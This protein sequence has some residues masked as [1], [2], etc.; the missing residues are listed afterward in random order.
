MSDLFS[1]H[2]G[3]LINLRKLY[4]RAPK[5]FLRITANMLTSFAFGNRKESLDIIHSK[6]TIRNPKFISR[7]IRVIK[8]RGNEPISRQESIVGSLTTDRFS[9]LKEQELGTKTKRTRV[10]SLL[11]RFGDIKRQAKP[12]A[13]LKPGNQF[14][15][16]DDFPGKSS[17]HRVISM[18]QIL[19]REK[20]KK[21][22]IIKG[23]R[24]FKSGLYQ[25]YRR[26]LRQLQSFEPDSPQPKRVRW[27]SGGRKKFFATA[28]IRK[29]WANS[30][31]RV[32][33]FK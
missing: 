17:Q 3:D 31:R 27:L 4:K 32:L 23:H 18:L 1:I 5:K 24:K 33:K 6:M 8:A 19:G 26:K 2:G 7:M 29:M 16:P 22:F 25:F 11:A 28:N 9:G 12:S 13:R 14:L 30:L 20:H 15:T 10:F 21:P